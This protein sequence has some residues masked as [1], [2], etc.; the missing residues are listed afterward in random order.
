MFFKILKP[1]GTELHKPKSFW[2]TIKN[3]YLRK[4]NLKKFWN[5]L[6]KD[7]LP[8]ELVKITSL[9]IESESYYLISKFWKH[10]L[11]NHISF[12]SKIINEND[13]LKLILK[14]DYNSFTMLDEFSISKTINKNFG[15]LKINSN[16]LDKHEDLTISQSIQHNIALLILYLQIREKKVFE[17]YEKLNKQMYFDFNPILKIENK[18]FTQ[19]MLI[20]LS[21]YEKIFSLI[22]KKENIKILEVGAGYGRTANAIIS[23]NSNIKY[24][25]VDL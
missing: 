5:N 14:N 17:L 18:K 4:K 7:R 25:I 19:Q 2:S 9:F 11:I 8:S 24:V 12:I 16:F 3:A 13:S 20:S 10:C 15:E 6:N 21:E 1:K 23:L 22:N